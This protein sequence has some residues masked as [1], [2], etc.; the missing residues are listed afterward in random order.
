MIDSVSR[1]LSLSMGSLIL[2]LLLLLTGTGFIA[3]RQATDDSLSIALGQMAQARAQAHQDI[4]RQA[5]DSVR[6]LHDELLER[7]DKQ[8]TAATDRRFAE[9]FARADDGLWRLRPELVD[10]RR[11]P[12]L[13][14]RNADAPARRR[15]VA[16][17]EL[18]REQGPA[19]VP[20]FFSV[21]MDFV[22]VGLMV[23]A[24]GVDWGA[25]ATPATD[26]FDYPTMTGSRPENN[27]ERKLF[28]TPV[29]FD[30]QADAWMVSAIQPLDWQGRWV[31]TVGHDI[32]IDS[33]LANVDQNGATGEYHLIIDDKG[34][35]IAHPRLHDRIVEADGQLALSSLEDPLLA[36][37]DTTIR[38]S[39]QAFG[40]E[41]HLPGQHV[42]RNPH[43]DERHPRPHPP[44]ARRAT[45]AGR[46]A[47]QD[48]RRRQAPALDHQRHPRHL[49]DRSRQAATRTQ[50]FRPLQRARPCPFPARRAARAKGL[51]IRIDAD[52]V[53]SGCAATSCAC[54]RGCSTTPATRSSS[55]SAAITL[56]AKLLEA[57]GDELLVRFEVSDSGIGIDPEQAVPPVPVLHP[58]RHS[59]TRKLRRHRTGPGHHPPAG[60][61]D[62]RRSRRRKRARARQHLLVHRPPATR[63]RHSAA[64]ETCWWTPNGGCGRAHAAAPACCSPKTTHQPRSGARTAAWRRPAV[65][66]AEDGV[67]ALALARQH[68]Y[69]LVLMDIQMPNLDGLEA[70]RAIRACRAGASRSWP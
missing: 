59:T 1:R 13:Y 68:R 57:Q 39:G 18:L 14:L 31:G 49:Q 7:L 29:Y 16:S 63:P 24:R 8:D 26:N 21:Y 41:E 33:L 45:R 11:A 55:P 40:G 38:N 22:E 69:D 4:F 64:E 25:A 62:G 61:T 9:L 19:L 52:A 47:G 44:A 28:W 5:Q 30:A 42:A 36:Q 37:V 6:R 3:L 60:R 15:A 66:V 54:A 43:A 27:R 70:T 20:P 58:G 50:R 12:T 48:R 17:Y 56:A 10:T 23:Y 65:D 67:E 34:Q 35:L 32:T 51:E 53:P 2:A 46:A